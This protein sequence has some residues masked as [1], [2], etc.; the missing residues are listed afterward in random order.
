[1]YTYKE[2][3]KNPNKELH[4]KYYAQFVTGD[5]I[6][7]VINHIGFENIVNSGDYFFNDIPIEKWDRL[8][9]VLPFDR[10]LWKLDRKGISL[11][12]YVCIAKAAAR[13]IRSENQSEFV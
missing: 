1:M 8:F 5:T 11:S 12:E 3:M 4:H 13:I 7:Y 10:E 9:M 2:Y 6:H